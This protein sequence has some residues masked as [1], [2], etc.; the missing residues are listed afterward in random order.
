MVIEIFDKDSRNTLLP[1]LKDMLLLL[2]EHKEELVWS[3]LEAEVIRKANGTVN[4]SELEDQVYSWTDIIRIADEFFQ[5]INIIVVAC[6]E[7]RL[8]PRPGEDEDYYSPCEIVIEGVDTTLWRVYARNAQDLEQI[9]KTYC[10]VDVVQ[11]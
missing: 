11:E 5:E 6:K 7:E 1:S 2:P 4:V 10:K 9:R 3:I 8:I